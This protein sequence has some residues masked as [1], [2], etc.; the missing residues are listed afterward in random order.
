[1]NCTD[2]GMVWL[3]HFMTPKLPRQPRFWPLGPAA[4]LTSQLLA[5]K[6][7]A[8]QRSPKPRNSM[9]TSI[10]VAKREEF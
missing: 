8:F 10:T 5:G 9:K 7:I 4:T 2:N 6:H 1:M 3:I